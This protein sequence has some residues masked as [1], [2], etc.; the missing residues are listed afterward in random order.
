MSEQNWPEPLD[1][2]PDSEDIRDML[3]GDEGAAATDGCYPI[4]ADGTCEHG[5]PSWP[6]YLGLI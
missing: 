2:R 5:Y 3:Y 4:E 6:L 1:Y